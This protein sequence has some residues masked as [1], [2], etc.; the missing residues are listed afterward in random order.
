M[1]QLRHASAYLMRA[2]SAPAGHSLPHAL[3][4]QTLSTPTLLGLRDRDNY[5]MVDTP[6][7]AS[8]KRTCTEYCMLGRCI[9]CLL[10]A[11]SVAVSHSSL[12]YS[13]V[14]FGS[15]MR[16]CPFSA[17]LNLSLPSSFLT[18]AALPKISHKMS[19]WRK[20]LQLRGLDPT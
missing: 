8:T 7:S 9:R 3:T 4:Q 16:F 17:A 11:A 18:G 10:Y 5:I 15:R 6:S 13:M 14:A 1:V 20:D 2:S 12:W 19:A